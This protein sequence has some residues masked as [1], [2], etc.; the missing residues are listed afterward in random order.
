MMINS[1][2]SF[3]KVKENSSSGLSV[4]HGRGNII[5]QLNQCH[6][7]RMISTKSKLIVMK[8][9]MICQVFTDMIINHFFVKFR[10]SWKNGN[11]PIIF[12]LFWI[13]GF[14]NRENFVILRVLG[15]HPPTS[16]P[17]SLSYPSR[18][19]GW[20]WSRVSQNLGDYKQTTWGR[21]G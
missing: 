13:T 18:D 17:G 19:P 21:G 5:N 1:V 16:F 10:K 8:K 14:K 4:I 2:K 11:G 20:V 6:V 7:H 9:I 15:K 3:Q 12:K